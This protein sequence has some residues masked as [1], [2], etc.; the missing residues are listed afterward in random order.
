MD[1]HNLLEST[2]TDQEDVSI[3]HLA[4]DLYTRDIFQDTSRKKTMDVT[5]I[6]SLPK[7]LRKV[8]MAVLKLNGGTIDEIAESVESTRTEAKNSLDRLTF[9][10]LLIKKEEQNQ[11]I[12]KYRE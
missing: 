4:G 8:G 12:Y 9:M 11:I 7:K 2:S 6:L 10:K 5:T 3:D 1:Y